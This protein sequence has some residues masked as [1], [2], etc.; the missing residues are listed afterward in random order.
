MKKRLVFFITVSL[1]LLAFI[2]NQGSVLNTDVRS[3]SVVHA[4]DRQTTLKKGD[5]G[6]SVRNLQSS[7]VKLYYLSKEY[8]TGS[9]DD[10]T[11]MATTAFQ[12]DHSL[13]ATGIA[14]EAT[15]LAI[16]NSLNSPT[17]YP[18]I[19]PTV[20][21]QPAVTSDKS[22]ITLQKGS[23][24]HDVMVLQMRLIQLGYLNG[25]ADGSFGKQTAKA[26]SAYQSANHHKAD[27]IATPAV[28]AALFSASAIGASGRQ[29]AEFDPSTY[30]TPTPKPTATPKPA[31]RTQK[32]NNVKASAGGSSGGSSGGTSYIGNKNTMKFHRL[33][34]SSINEMKDKNKVALSTR[35]EAIQ[36]GYVPC[37]RC[38]P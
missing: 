35:N 12:M 20:Y 9:F 29:Y 25:K 21:S 14:D 17:S 18:D 36:K 32:A 5:S 22:Y 30:A 27:G 15:L 2:T 26:L 11:E 19:E 38:N 23:R 16:S 34:C 6:E 37:K 13:D 10:Y 4:E 8:A 24:G 28:Q 7:L 1:C 33:G 3:A 31:K